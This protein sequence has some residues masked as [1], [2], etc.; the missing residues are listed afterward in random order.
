[1]AQGSLS[2]LDALRDAAR[3]L[4]SEPVGAFD[5]LPPLLAPLAALVLV[6]AAG[7]RAL[8][9]SVLVAA[10][11]AAAAVL[12]AYPRFSATHVVWANA[13]MIAC[14]ASAIGPDLAARRALTVALAVPLAMG[15]VIA[16]SLVP[17]SWARGDLTFSSLPSFAGVPIAQASENTGRRV[18]RSVT[19]G[20]AVLF[21]T[22]NAGFFTLVTR[23][24][25]PTPYDVPASSNIGKSEI[26]E[27]LRG[28]RAGTIQSACFGGAR[29]FSEEPSLRPLA[30]EHALETVMRPT[31]DI[32]AC[33][34][35]VPMP[36]G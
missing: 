17:V 33:V 31:A 24:R 2:Y 23:A 27:V 28:V 1:V 12:G 5:N 11:F 8:S 30:L 16:V 32:G 14:A 20:E 15:C 34:L 13:A 10:A 21:V 26:R 36:P 4:P 29:A 25:N 3:L 9:T 19:P 18:Q 7:R 22:E 35:H 6:A